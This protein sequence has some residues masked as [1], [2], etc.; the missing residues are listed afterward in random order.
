[1]TVFEA[2]CCDH[3]R[4]QNSFFDEFCI[5]SDVCGLNCVLV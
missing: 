2:L 3:S 5:K 4:A 1:M